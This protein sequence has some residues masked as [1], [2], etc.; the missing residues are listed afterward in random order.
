MLDSIEVVW[1][2][3]RQQTNALLAL[4]LLKPI[5]DKLGTIQP[6]KPTSDLAKCNPAHAEAAGNSIPTI[7][8]SERAKAVGRQ[9]GRAHITWSQ[10]K[11]RGAGT[12][13][14]T[15]SRKLTNTDSTQAEPA[16]HFPF[17]KGNER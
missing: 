13:G 3:D 2:Q 6:A 15:N 11:V 8:T 7:Q 14:S 1:R 10:S 9:H 5:E 16:N 12:S 4:I 17:P